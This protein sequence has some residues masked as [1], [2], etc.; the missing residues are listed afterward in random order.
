MEKAKELL[1]TGM[2]ISKTFSKLYKP[3]NPNESLQN[4]KQ[5]ENMRYRM[6]AADRGN[7]KISNI[8]DEAQLIEDYLDKVCL[9]FPNE[10]H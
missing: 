2:S 7:M 3:E 4:Q 5:L 1:K 8:V 9:I 10:V 6:N